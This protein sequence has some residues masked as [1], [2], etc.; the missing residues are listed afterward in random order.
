MPN[1]LIHPAM[2]VLAVLLIS[3]PCAALAVDEGIQLN[4][5]PGS[6]AV[7]V[8]EDEAN[9]RVR[10]APGGST[11]WFFGGG[12]GLG[13]GD[14]DFFEVSPLLG[15]WLNPKVSLGGTLIYRYRRDSRTP[16]TIST[17]DY[18]GSIFG[19]YLVWDPLYLHAEVEYLNYEYINYDLST[20]REGFTSFFL[21]A[22]AATP[23]SRN[24]S[25]FAT[26]LYNLAYSSNE[27]SPYG[28][29]WVV[30]VGVGFGF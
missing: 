5:T 10:F 25:F 26:I 7:L 18:G 20:D 28:S 27:R 8:E 12:V 30:R 2:R 22:G 11:N 16:E 6:A 15:V 14:V 4:T 1:Q 3:C 17:S 13:F 19:R 9:S 24:A 23:I 21:G 29:P